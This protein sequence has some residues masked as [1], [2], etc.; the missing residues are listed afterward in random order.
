M[1]LSFPEPLIF[2]ELKVCPALGFISYPI[3]KALSGRGCEVRWLTYL[4]AIVLL[5]YFVL[6]QGLIG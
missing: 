5:V 3:I 4:L 1:G 2:L 6:V